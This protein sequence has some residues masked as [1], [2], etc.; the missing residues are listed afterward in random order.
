M[1]RPFDVAIVGLGA[2]GSAAAF[3]LAR[4]GARVVGVD[5]WRPPH[6]HGSTHGRTR[7]IR[8]AYYEHPVYVPL[9]RRAYELWDALE[10]QVGERLFVRTGGVMA[11]P[12]GGVLV[13]GA[14]R[15]ARGHGLPHELVDAD[16]LR[17]RFPALAPAPDWVAVIEPRAGLL[18]PERCVEAHLRLAEA[19]GATLRLGEPVTAWHA[20]D[21]GVRLTT[22]AGELRAGRLLMTAGP[23]LPG[24]VAP[25]ALPLAVE[26][27]TFHWTRPAARPELCRADRAPIALWEYEPGRLFATFPD[28][29]HGVKCGVHHEG[30][31]V[32]DPDA[33]RRTVDD[34]ET[35]ATRALLRRVMPDADGTLLDRS[36]CL[37]TNTPDHHFLI[38]AHP[39]HPRV[40]LAS[41]CS[42]HGFK[43]SSAIGELLADLLAGT[44]PR[45][46]PTPFRLGRPSLAATPA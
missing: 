21:A 40:L 35:A 45:F 18:L 44:V 33:V 9:V 24:L 2:M 11:G 31:T 25:L 20:D 14:L 36:V 43:F 13:D 22:D 6:G 7:I 23:W 28:I 17:R 37:Y 27:Q 15:S 46:D 8:E 32:T 19:A 12:P 10:R 29:G 4:R 41:P 30:E 34:G 39:E 38:D 16:E 5:R 26:R 1:T 42:G 3:H